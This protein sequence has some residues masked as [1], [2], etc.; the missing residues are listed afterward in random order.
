MTS[1]KNVAAV[2]RFTIQTMAFNPD[3]LILFYLTLGLLAIPLAVIAIIA[4]R[5]ENRQSKQ[6]R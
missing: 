1:G 3:N 2:R 4:N 6:K 5:E